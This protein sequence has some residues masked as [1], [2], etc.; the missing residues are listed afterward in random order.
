MKQ[1][2]SVYIK[3]DFDATSCNVIQ[4]IEQDCSKGLFLAL[5]LKCAICIRDL[6][7]RMEENH[8]SCDEIASD[9]LFCEHN[10]LPQLP[11]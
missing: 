9:E 1:K 6:R 7:L 10:Q 4:I 3:F 2:R 8:R 5:C 11:T